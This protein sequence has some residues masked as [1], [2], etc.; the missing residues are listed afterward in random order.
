MN[1]SSW[2]KNSP[3]NRLDAELILAHT[4]GVERTFLHTH[5]ERELTPDEQSRADSFAARRSRHEPLAYILGYKEFF[6]Q[7]FAVTP[8]VLIPRPETEALINEI[9]QIA[10]PTSKILDVGTGSGCIAITL[11]K[12]LK[13]AE[14][15]GVDISEKALKIARQNAQTLSVDVDFHLSN[16]LEETAK[17]DIIVANLPYVDQNWDWLSPDLAFEPKNGLHIL[18]KR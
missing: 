12:A 10:K 6:G 17:Y 11:K 7:S 1:A 8:D 13:N 4:L 16:L 18:Y 2:L 14:I 15:T 3:L 5:P 9:V